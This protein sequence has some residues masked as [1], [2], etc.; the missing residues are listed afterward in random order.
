D[1]ISHLHERDA[2]NERSN[3]PA[4]SRSSCPTSTNPTITLGMRMA[5]QDGDGGDSGSRTWVP[6][7]VWKFFT[8]F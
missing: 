7:E 3:Y 1:G 4:T 5:S 2:S 6:A 8:Q